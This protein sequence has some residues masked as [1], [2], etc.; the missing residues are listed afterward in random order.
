M[1]T[2]LHVGAMLSFGK[3]RILPVPAPGG[4][5]SNE[6]EKYGE[7]VEACST[8][9]PSA[10]RC[11]LAPPRAGVSVSGECATPPFAPRRD[12]RDRLAVTSAGGQIGH[13]EGEDL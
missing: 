7:E 10:R 11:R 2:S 13:V 12:F 4:L 5:S 8:S 9:S 6:S 1:L 3:Q